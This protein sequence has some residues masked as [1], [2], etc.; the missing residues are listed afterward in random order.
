GTCAGLRFAPWVV[1]LNRRHYRGRPQ[2]P[3]PPSKFR[4]ATP[5]PPLSENGIETDM[6][7]VFGQ[8]DWMRDRAPLYTVVERILS[9]GE[10]L[11]AEWPVDGTSGY[12]STAVATGVSMRRRSDHFF[13]NPST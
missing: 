4:G 10:A 13:T 6:Q 9:P 12:E 7:Q 11:P 5:H 3:S 8:H 2:M 1:F